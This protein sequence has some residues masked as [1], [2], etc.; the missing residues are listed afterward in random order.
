M[1]IDDDL[2]KCVVFFGL[3]DDSPEG[4]GIRCGGTG[5][6]LRYEEFGY[7]V[8]ARHV[9]ET[10][11][12]DPFIVRINMK[13]GTAQNLDADQVRWYFH[14]DP[15][16]D[17][18]V[19]PFTLGGG[20]FDAVY[21]PIE[22]LAPDSEIQNDASTI[23]F[24]G[25]FGPGDLTY[26]IGL[27]ALLSGKKRNLAVV[28]SGSIA[29]IPRDEKIP[30]TDWRDKRNTIYVEGYL[31]ETHARPGLSGSPVFVRRTLNFSSLPGN[32]IMDPRFS[33]GKDFLVS[34]PQTMF[35]LLGLWQ[36]SWDAPPD[37]VVAITTG[38]SVR[39]PVGMG[40]AAPAYKIKETLET[41]ELME[42]RRL[43]KETANA[44][45]AATPD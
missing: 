13:D 23:R 24:L 4:G 27:F 17:V 19:I 7:I 10:L 26:T 21:I 31:L 44:K 40:I 29:A 34:A 15:D 33:G 25:S 45:N 20:N 8:T 6:L 12:A 5:F 35:H 32:L 37:D 42:M 11:G 22:M 28:H 18:A 30:V 38:R 1:R 41:A 14:P 16:V 39:V 36:S 43:W 3:P 2:R 9:A